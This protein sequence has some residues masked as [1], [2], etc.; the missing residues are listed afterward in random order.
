MSDNAGGDV[1]VTI[2]ALIFSNKHKR[3]RGGK[4][5]KVVGIK[6]F[7]ENTVLFAVAWFSG[8]ASATHMKSK[9]TPAPLTATM[10]WPR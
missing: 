10:P 3:S 9:N 6:C 1:T 2:P 8:A 4:W 7:S 5:E